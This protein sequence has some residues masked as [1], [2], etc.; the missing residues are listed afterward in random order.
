MRDR[1]EENLVGT[2]YEQTSKLKAHIVSLKEKNK[3]LSEE[4]ERKK[5][6]LSTCKKRLAVMPVSS[7]GAKNNDRHEIS[8]EIQII[9]ARTKP[10]NASRESLSAGGNRTDDNLLAIAQKLK[11]R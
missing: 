3:I 11:E 10:I 9:A 6:E 7:G 8:P 1:E 5:K 2:L 4:L